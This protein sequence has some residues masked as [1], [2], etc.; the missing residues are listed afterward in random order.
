M[1]RLSLL[2]E[3]KAGH[4]PVLIVDEAQHLRRPILQLLKFLL[5]YETNT[6]KLIQILLLGQTELAANIRRLPELKSRMFPAAL[7]ELSAEDTAEM[8]SWRFRTAGGG[9]VPFT[10]RALM[11]IFRYS[12]GLPREVCRIADLALLAGFRDG[13]QT[14]DEPTVNLAAA[15]LDLIPARPLEVPSGR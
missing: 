13:I 15:E 4:S 7:R 10:P 3:F 9:K 6:Q 5:N 11:A 1:R 14:I 2:G 8:I 12:A